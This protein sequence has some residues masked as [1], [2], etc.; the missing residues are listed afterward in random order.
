MNDNVTL[1][2]Q[3]RNG[4][5]LSQRLSASFWKYIS[6]FL[7]Q[8]KIITASNALNIRNKQF[9]ACWNLI[10]SSAFSATLLITIKQCVCSLI[11]WPSRQ[12]KQ[13]VSL[14]TETEWKYQNPNNTSQL[15]KTKWY[16]INQY[17]M[18]NKMLNCYG[19]Y[20]NENESKQN[21]LTIMN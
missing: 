17:C 13:T 2:T 8:H 6:T 5:M 15:H 4:K 10:N 14:E 19:F 1:H 3:K 18:Q 12:D 7:N 20:D 21:L 11:T 9:S 16:L